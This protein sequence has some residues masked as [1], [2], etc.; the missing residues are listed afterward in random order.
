MRFAT[1]L[2]VLAFTAPVDSFS[3]YAPRVRATSRPMALTALADPSLVTDTSMAL[4]VAEWKKWAFS[5]VMILSVTH[6]LLPSPE[7][8]KA[9]QAPDDTKKRTRDPTMLA[10]PDMARRTALGAALLMLIPRQAAAADADSVLPGELD[11][12]IS[13]MKYAL[14]KRRE[15]QQ[16]CYD[17]GDCADATPY[18][19]IQCERGDT[20]C[21]QL[22]RRLANKEFKD[23]GANPLS[24]P[25]LLVFFGGAALQWGSLGLKFVYRLLERL[26]NTR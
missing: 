14:K 26:N 19:A 15:E 13:P 18:Y 24:S 22:K 11:V 12:L 1:S 10:E 8:F 3:T 4:P 9:K 2:A 5:A 16:S 23:F 20:E 7:A 17:E 21:L 6:P 25:I